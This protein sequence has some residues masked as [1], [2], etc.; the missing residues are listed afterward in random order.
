[1][2]LLI[3]VQFVV[4]YTMDAGGSGRGRGRGRGGDSGRGRGRGGG[5]DPFAD[6]TWLT[7]HVVLGATIL[8]LALVRLVWRVVTP[9]PP[10]ADTLSPGERTLAHWTER[11][12]YMLML[13]I[14]STGLW[15]IVADDDDALAPHV[16][17]HVAFFVVIAAHVGLVLKHQLVNRDRLL[18]RML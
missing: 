11:L 9:L 2:A 3:L 12:L 4:G 15:L 7:V 8:T 6:D 16:V 13:A 1:M 18:R 14:P 5:Y 10:W 17:S